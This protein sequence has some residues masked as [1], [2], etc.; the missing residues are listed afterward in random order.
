MDARLQTRQLVADTFERIV[1]YHRGM[2]PYEAPKGVID[3]LLLAKGGRARLLRIDRRGGLVAAEDV[4]SAAEP[5][6][7]IG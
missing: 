7:G 6:A 1:I 5:I 3:V 2:R 4:T